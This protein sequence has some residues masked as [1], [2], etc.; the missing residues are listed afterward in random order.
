MC[1]DDIGGRFNVKENEG[2]PCSPICVLNIADR[3]EQILC[4]GL[5]AKR[6]LFPGGLSRNYLPRLARNE[7]HVDRHADLQ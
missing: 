6:G 1:G 3:C 2:S 4:L 5:F 7:Y